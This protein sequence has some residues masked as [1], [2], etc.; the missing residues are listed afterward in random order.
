MVGCYI[1]TRDIFFG[2]GGKALK[3]V[4]RRPSLAHAQCQFESY[5]IEGLTNA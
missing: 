3:D 2:L 1:V 5:D 4:E